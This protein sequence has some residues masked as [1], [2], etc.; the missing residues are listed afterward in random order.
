M[1]LKLTKLLHKLINDLL[2][3]HIHVFCT[4]VI[5]VLTLRVGHDHKTLMSFN[6]NMLCQV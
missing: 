5:P 2:Q 4:R 3:S 1:S 6:A